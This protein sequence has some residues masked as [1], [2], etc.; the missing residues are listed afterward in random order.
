MTLGRLITFEGG[1]GAGKSTQVRLLAAS[2]SDQGLDVLQTREPGGCPAAEEVR[3][4]LVEGP[5][6][7]WLPLS[8][9][10]LHSVARLEHLTRL[11]RPALEAGRWVLC[12]RF[13][14]ST[15]AY[16]GY[17]HGLGA[18]PV[19]TLRDLVTGG[20]VPDLTLILDLPVD[21][22][23]GRAAHRADGGRRYEALDDAFHNRVRDGFLEIARREPQRC[24]VVDA[25][26]SEEEVASAVRDL[27]AERLGAALP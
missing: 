6:D 18:Q 22:G 20:L 23:L 16:Q 2:L 17:G 26:R 11:V 1:E 10:M 19:E 24:A 3:R 14:D 21:I 25:S 12:D 13:T 27:V 4:L 9:A 15:M 5:A 7:R 8:E